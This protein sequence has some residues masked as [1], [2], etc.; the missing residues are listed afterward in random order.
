LS[1]RTP[2]PRTLGRVLETVLYVGD[3]DAA[4]TFYGDV[5]GLPEASRRQGLFVFYRLEA[6]MLLLFEPEAAQRS[7]SVPPHGASG[8]GHVALAVADADID[9]WRR[10]LEAKGIA[11]EAEVTWPRGGRSLYF[12][13]P[14]GN[15]VELAAPSIWGF[16]DPGAGA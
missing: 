2:Q 1:G 6:A 11:I 8:P 4:A 7:T 12:R 14:A 3:L 16:D 10:H 5:L 15:S 9:G 13:D